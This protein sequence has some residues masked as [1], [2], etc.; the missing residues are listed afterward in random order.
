MSKTI[1]VTR[2]KD[3]NLEIKTEGFSGEAC[4]DATKT[5]KERLGVVTSETATDEMYNNND[6]TISNEGY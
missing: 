5:L 2:K 3:G 1:I 4:K 6:N